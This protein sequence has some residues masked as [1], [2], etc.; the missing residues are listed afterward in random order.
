MQ[1]QALMSSRARRYN[2]P[3]LFSIAAG[4]RIGKGCVHAAVPR[5]AGL[6]GNPARAANAVRLALLNLSV[7]RAA[8]ERR[9]EVVRAVPASRSH[10]MD[11]RPALA[12]KADVREI[13]S[14]Q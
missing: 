10:A 14:W 4:E 13:A 12:A 6:L 5:S 9:F 3:L 2:A 11:A 7:G 8:P 1:A